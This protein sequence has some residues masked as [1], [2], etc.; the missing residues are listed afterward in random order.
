[1]NAVRRAW[2]W[3]RKNKTVIAAG[4]LTGGELAVNLGVPLPGAELI[5]PGARG[6]AIVLLVVA[7]M[8]FGFKAEREARDA[9]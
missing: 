3:A 7:R 5:P 1:M 9:R 8:Y 6:T 2:A 4:V